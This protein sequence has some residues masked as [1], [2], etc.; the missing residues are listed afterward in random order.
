MKIVNS[1]A[2]AISIFYQ[3]N[4]TLNVHSLYEYLYSTYYVQVLVQAQKNTVVDKIKKKKKCPYS[5]RR[6]EYTPTNKKCKIPKV[7]SPNKNV[8]IQ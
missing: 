5:N 3:L 4:A 7:V 8:K 6:T 2:A 1:L